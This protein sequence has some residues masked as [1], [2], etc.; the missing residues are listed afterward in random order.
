MELLQTYSKVFKTSY[1]PFLAYPISE[2]DG[3]HFLASTFSISGI[4]HAPNEY[5]IR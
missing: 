4:C 3:R 5:L 1:N 2:P